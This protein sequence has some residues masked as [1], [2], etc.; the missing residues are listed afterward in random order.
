MN[1]E[2]GIHTLN[3]YVHN[4]VNLLKYI[5]EDAVIENKDTLEMLELALQKENEIIE[6]I[7]NLKTRK[8]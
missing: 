3:G 1:F 5:K 8:L 2:D 7:N 4:V 6:V